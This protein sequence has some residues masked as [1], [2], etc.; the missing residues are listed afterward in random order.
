MTRCVITIMSFLGQSGLLS[1]WTRKKHYIYKLIA[2][3]VYPPS[4]SSPSNTKEST[5]SI[6]IVFPV[7]TTTSRSNPSP[8]TAKVPRNPTINLHL[9]PTNG[10][11]RQ[12]SGSGFGNAPWSKQLKTVQMPSPPPSTGDKDEYYEDCHTVDNWRSVQ[13]RRWELI[14][15]GRLPN[16]LVEAVQRK[17]W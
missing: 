6:Q 4:A 10:S 5:K 7:Q 17:S 13:V 15:M 14:L 3:S 16:L 8:V 9:Q 12:T 2:E 11:K 1:K